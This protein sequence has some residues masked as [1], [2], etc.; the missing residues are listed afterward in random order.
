MSM[1]GGELISPGFSHNISKEKKSLSKVDE[2][3]LVKM[4]TLIKKEKLFSRIR[5]LIQETTN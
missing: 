1:E 4:K 5:L 3:D 2:A